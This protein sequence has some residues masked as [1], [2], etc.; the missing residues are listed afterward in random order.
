MLGSYCDQLKKH[1]IFVN[2]R[3]SVILESNVD[4]N[5]VPLISQILIYDYVILRTLSI[6]FNGNIDVTEMMFS[7]AIFY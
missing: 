2:I 1:L 3:L 4:E 6:S 5:A 7:D